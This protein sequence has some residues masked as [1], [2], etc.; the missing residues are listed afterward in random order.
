MSVAWMHGKDAG[1]GEMVRWGADRL[2]Q[3]W[4]EPSNRVFAL[5]MTEEDSQTELFVQ[6]KKGIKHQTSTYDEIRSP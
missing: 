6:R 5:Q 1:R 4:R 3:G 2:R